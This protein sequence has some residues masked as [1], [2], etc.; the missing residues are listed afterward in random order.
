MAAAAL[1]H[2]SGPQR[3]SEVRRAI[4]RFGNTPVSGM[5]PHRIARMGIGFVPEGHRCFP[6]LMVR[7]NLAVAARPGAWTLPRIGTLFP[8]LEERQSQYANTL[9]GGELQMLSIGRALMTNPKLLILDEATEGLA[10]LVR[11]RIWA[12]IRRLKAEGQAILVVDK[13]LAE[14]LPVADRAFVL[15][16]GSTVWSGRPE[17][18]TVELQDRYL[19]IRP[20]TRRNPW[21]QVVE[22]S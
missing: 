15:E 9:S 3:D 22:Q 10:P 20:V 1:A 13:A 7:E 6:N 14:L 8:P 16:K 17:E 5:P 18:L 21:R 19:G 4:V 2:R 12:A 11:Q